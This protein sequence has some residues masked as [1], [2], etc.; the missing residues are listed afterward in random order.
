M[1]IEIFANLIFIL[2]V[3]VSTHLEQVLTVTLPHVMAENGQEHLLVVGTMGNLLDKVK[4]IVL[5]ALSAE[6]L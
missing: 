5:W 3:Q 1:Y 2:C 6:I 4:V